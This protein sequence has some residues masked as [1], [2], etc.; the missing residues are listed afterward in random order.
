MKF[1]SAGNYK[2]KKRGGGVGGGAFQKWKVWAEV[3]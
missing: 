2:K 3:S 1:M